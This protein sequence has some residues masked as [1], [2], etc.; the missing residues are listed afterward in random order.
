MSDRLRLAL[1]DDVPGLFLLRSRSGPD[2]GLEIRDSTVRVI[3]L[4]ALGGMLWRPLLSIAVEPH[5]AD[6][7]IVVGAR[8]RIERE[9][10][11]T[12]EATEVVLAIDRPLSDADAA[13][14]D[15]ALRRT[16]PGS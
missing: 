6:G 14:V 4:A 2:Y 7:V 1:H 3:R 12:V 9:P 16:A 5:E 10:T 13:A 8:H 11:P 15:A